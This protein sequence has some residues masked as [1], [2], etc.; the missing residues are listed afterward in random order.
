MNIINYQIEGLDLH[1]ETES[2]SSWENHPTAYL[3]RSIRSVTGMSVTEFC[4]WLG[5]PPRT[6]QQWEKG[7]RAM[8]EYLLRLIAYKVQMELQ[9]GRI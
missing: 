8:P 1:I 3:I 9:L 7:D 6:M 2:K 4:K 5:I